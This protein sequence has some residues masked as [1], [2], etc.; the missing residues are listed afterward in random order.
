MP[1]MCSRE[2]VWNMRP[3]SRSCHRNTPRR[4]RLSKRQERLRQRLPL[5]H[6]SKLRPDVPKQLVYAVHK[7][8]VLVHHGGKVD[9]F[10][11]SLELH[12]AACNLIDKDGARLLGI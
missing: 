9:I 12:Q 3:H 1:R 11:V 4:Q 2:N 6:T 7:P 10:C 5:L 8:L